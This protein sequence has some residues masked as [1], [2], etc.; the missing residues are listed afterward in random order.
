MK[1]V[2]LKSRFAAYYFKYLSWDSR[3]F[4]KSSY[5][6]DPGK[7]KLTPDRS[8]AQKISQLFKNTFISLKI[9]F[10]AGKELILF[11][12][13]AGFIYIN[14]EIVMKYSCCVQDKPEADRRIILSQLKKNTGLPY[15]EIGS[16]FIHTRFHRDMQI[17]KKQADRV[18]VEYLKNYQP[19]KSHHLFLA[20]YKGQGAG[21]ILVNEDKGKKSAYLFYV[22]VVKELQDKRIGSRL[23]Q[24]VAGKFPEYR[25]YTGTQASNLPALN[26]Y[27]KN[28]FSAIED[29]KFVMHRW[30]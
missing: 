14:T 27:L 2:V 21:V 5:Q 22:A 7:S 11:L 16:V 29:T 4:H 17:S 24:Y 12:Q 20:T 10:S 8:I 13:K 19:D 9:D 3:F 15:N 26:F 28:G 6:L 30:G 18:W 23:I 25:L 1:D